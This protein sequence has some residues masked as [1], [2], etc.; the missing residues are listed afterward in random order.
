[1][2]V[3]GDVFVAGVDRK[4]VFGATMKRPTR[5]QV[6]KAKDEIAAEDY[7]KS[8]LERGD[9]DVV[10]ENSRRSSLPSEHPE[11]IHGMMCDGQD[12]M[13]SYCVRLRTKLFGGKT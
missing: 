11:H 2:F 6:A 12:G 9:E 10:A 3:V 4:A 8:I 1:M 5:K 7:A 13:N